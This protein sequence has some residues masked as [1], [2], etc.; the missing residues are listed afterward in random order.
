MPGVGSCRRAHAFARASRCLL[1]AIGALVS[2]IGCAKP[3]PPR[4]VI[5]VLVDTLR[6][7]RLGAY[8]NT[9]G[10]TP[11]LDSLAGRAYVFHNAYSQAPW[12]S[13]SVAAL[14]TSR[15]PN[16]L[17][18]VTFAS[19]VQ[20]RETVLAE[21]LHDHGYSTGAFLA[22]WFLL[23]RGFE[24]GFDAFQQRRFAGERKTRGTHLNDQAFAW[25]DRGAANERSRHLHY[26][27]P[28]VPYA[29][30]ADALDRA[31]AWNER[32]PLF[33]YLHYP[34][35][36]VP[37]AP[38]ADA[39]DRAFAWLDQR[40]SGESPIFLYLHYTEPHVPYAPPGDALK[41]VRGDGVTPDLNAVNALIVNKNRAPSAL[42]AA[43][44]HDVTDVYDAEVASL[45]D[46]LRALFDG[47]KARHLLD[48]AVVV[49]TADHG[50]SFQEHG[51][52]GHGNS[53]F[54]DLVRVPLLIALPGMPARI[55]VDEPVALIDVAPTLLDLV[56]ITA[57]NSFE[58]QTL[59]PAML[60]GATRW[61]GPLRRL[62]AGAPDDDRP[63]FT[64]RSAAL[65]VN[66]QHERAVVIGR[67]K[68]IAASGLAGEFYDLAADPEEQRPDALS[69]ADRDRLRRALAERTDHLDHGSAVPTSAPID[70]ETR[71][72]M[73]A[74]GYGDQ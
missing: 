20:E 44:L 27:E 32:S 60:R 9:R 24:Q 36:H 14:F 64:E 57:P 35:P 13:P 39:L 30:P 55:D 73:Q 63:L 15:I 28:H 53:L 1:V 38:P 37:Y 25:L 70:A 59:R 66:P 18:I 72:R 69:A 45:D 16:E 43:Q 29:P 56:G 12:T 4:N 6:A 2:L 7:D 42:T 41:R 11:F 54:N 47:L 17:G 52:V 46:T 65:V 71:E 23:G 33:T 5:I 26:P 21:V 74:L 62:W 51:Y 10:L 8:G 34:E 58:G 61:L 3:I 50:E 22:H 67:E 49:V 19:N 31:F 48:D 40:G 68:Y